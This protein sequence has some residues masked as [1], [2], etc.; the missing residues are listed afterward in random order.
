MNGCVVLL[1]L[2]L[3]S[4][5]TCLLPKRS[6][7]VRMILLA[8]KEAIYTPDQ[9]RPISLLD[10]FLKVQERLFLNRFIQVL[11]DRGILPD[12]QSG[13]RGGHRLQTRVLLLIEQISL[14]MSN[15]SPIA[16]VFC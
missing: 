12:N 4:F 5:S 1:L 14:S 2:L 11:K 13:F 7:D 10:S 9:T 6:K 8:K 3:H 15:S 16:T